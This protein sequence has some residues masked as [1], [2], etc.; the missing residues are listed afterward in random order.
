MSNYV[1]TFRDMGSHRTLEGQV[2]KTGV[3]FRSGDLAGL[4]PED[5]EQLRQL[6]LKLIIDLRT[7]K[8]RKSKPDRLPQ[9]EVIRVVNVPLDRMN[10]EP[11]PQMLFRFLRGWPEGGDFEQFTRDY[12]EGLVFEDTAQVAEIFSLISDTH[13]LPALIH[14]TAGKD[15]TGLI[16]ALI[17]LAVGVPRETVIQDFLASNHYYEP[18]MQMYI[19]RIRWMTLFQVPSERIRRIFVVRREYLEHVLDRITET[20]GN[21]SGYLRKGCGIDP[22]II[23]RLRQ[24]L[25]E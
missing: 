8:E 23:M 13:N 22:M 2:M 4:S 10:L 6:H 25:L 20:Y 18:V 14:C 7:P 17:Q 16:A 5:M 11:V 3:L 12:Y 19:R 21:V 24:L 9:P 1:S 15:R